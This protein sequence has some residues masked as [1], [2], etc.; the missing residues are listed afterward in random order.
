LSETDF[1]S[2]DLDWLLAFFSRE[3]D[4][5]VRPVVVEATAGDGAMAALFPYIEYA[6]L[7]DGGS[8]GVLS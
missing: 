4:G 8:D 5:E 2:A 7:S 6:W 1:K 3:L